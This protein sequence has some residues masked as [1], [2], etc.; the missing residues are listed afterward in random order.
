[1]RRRAIPIVITAAILAPGIIAGTWVAA[2][3]AHR[4]S[5]APPALLVYPSRTT[6][7]YVPR[8]AGAPQA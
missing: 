1:M 2:V 7:L 3:L 5:S 6:L 4:H 8:P